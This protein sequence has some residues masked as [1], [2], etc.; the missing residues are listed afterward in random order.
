MLVSFIIPAYN[1]AD[2]I[3]RCL[4][5]IYGLS[6]KREEFE[7][8]VI[9]DASTDDTCEIV[10][11]YAQQLANDGMSRDKSL[12]ESLTLNDVNLILL[13][14]PENHRQGAARNR[15][16]KEAKGEYICFVDADDTVKEGIVTAIR[17]AKV[18]QTDMVAYHCA[19]ANERGE[20]MREKEHLSF[21][22]GEV[23]S[24]IDMQNRHP[25]WFSGPVAYIYERAFLEF[26]DYS[27]AEGVLY[28][29]SDFV[30]VHLYHAK[31]MIYSQELG[32]LAYEREGSTTRH[33]SYKNVADYLLLGMRML[34]FYESI[35]ES[36]QLRAESQEVK[37]FVEGILEGASYNVTRACK[38]MVKLSD[39]KEVDAFYARVDVNAN[40]KELYENKAIK[41]YDWRAWNTICLKYPMMA[42]SCLMI[43]I[44][45]YKLYKK[46]K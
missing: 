45:L 14:Q 2:T 12:N 8:I 44:P 10:E 6:L 39:L 18:K 40:R 5:S 32:Y 34:R 37:K 36:Q 25:Y 46:T 20:I 19:S 31:R 15:G 28:E 11:Q 24:G 21:E 43:M 4:D 22:E 30:A 3:V 38:R 35:A 33:T 9:D 41:K 7:V 17:M 1:A 23:F 16:L 26:V 27:F 13:R 29:D 42:K